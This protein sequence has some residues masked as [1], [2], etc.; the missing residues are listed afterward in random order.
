[1]KAKVYAVVNPRENP[2][3]SIATEFPACVHEDP[4]APSSRKADA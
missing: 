4:L 3:S 1:M 2:S